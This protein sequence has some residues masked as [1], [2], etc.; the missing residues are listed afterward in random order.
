MK[1][2]SSS[3]YGQH[4]NR[5]TQEIVLL[6]IIIIGYFRKIEVHKYDN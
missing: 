2:H 4:K 6:F 5:E 3:Q 1:Q